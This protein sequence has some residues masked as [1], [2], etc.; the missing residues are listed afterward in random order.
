MCVAVKKCSFCNVHYPMSLFRI[1]K[2][3]NTIRNKCRLCENGLAREKR[4]TNPKPKSEAKKKQETE[5][6]LKNKEKRK[7]YL[8]QWRLANKERIKKKA[9]NKKLSKSKYSRVSIKE[10]PKC[11]SLSCIGIDRAVCSSCYNSYWKRVY[12]IGAQIKSGES[13]CKCGINK[14]YPFEMPSQGSK[15]CKKECAIEAKKVSLKKRR[16]NRTNHKTRDRLKKHKCFI[17]PIK[18]N[19]IFLRDN[20][21]CNKCGVKVQRKDYNADNSGEIDHIIPVSLRGAHSYFNT[22]V[23]CRKCNIDKSNKD[24]NKQLLIL[25]YI[26]HLIYA[27]GK[28]PFT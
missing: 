6:Y 16:K 17:E 1:N 13:K 10:C 23:L 5:W 3:N 22:Q 26:M 21:T 18:K 7:E 8:K 24:I 2:L 15:Y 19:K 27:E 11:G 14:I 20:Y 25:S 28:I 9:I 12:H 4:L